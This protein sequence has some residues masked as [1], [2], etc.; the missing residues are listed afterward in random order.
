MIEYTREVILG[1]TSAAIASQTITTTDS[2]T[3]VTGDTIFVR[4]PRP[5]DPLKAYLNQLRRAVRLAREQ[6]EMAFREVRS[7][8]RRLRDD[9]SD[10]VPLPERNGLRRRPMFAKRVCGGSSRYRVLVA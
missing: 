7:A 6:A 5:E 10:R 8:H 1:A 3:A 4:P 9:P 2:T